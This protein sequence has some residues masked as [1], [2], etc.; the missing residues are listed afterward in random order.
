L[1]RELNPDVVGLSVMTFQRATALQI[2]RLVRAL[3]PEVRIA[4]GGYDP[5]LAP[6]AY[7]AGGEVDFLIRGEGE[8]TFRDLLRAL[9]NGGSVRDIAGLSYRDGFVMRHNAERP[10]AHLSTDPLEL[11]K[12]RARVLDGYT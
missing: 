8:R 10:I 4:A 5:S 1:V 6:D 3:R 12:R 9:E 11:P 7:E 2:A